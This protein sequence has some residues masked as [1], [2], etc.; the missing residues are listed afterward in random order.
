MK[1]SEVDRLGERLRHEVSSQD[2]TLLDTYRRGFRPAYDVVVDRIRAE[3]GLEASGRPA[4]STAAIVDKLRRGT[5]RLTQMQ[6]IAG[7]RILVP[8]IPTQSQLIATLESMFEV[9]IVDRRIKPSHGYR[10]V[11]VIVQNTEFPVEVQL[12]TELQHTWAELSEKLA[13]AVGIDTKYGG[14]HTAIRERLDLYSELVASFEQHLD[15]DG[16]RDEPVNEHK[17]KIRLLMTNYMSAI[18]KKP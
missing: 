2:L 15:I 11:H 12:R 16:L 17:R 10:A 14:G 4:K 1:N 9:V 18:R 13:D 5:M 7:C 8:D 6:D 3:L